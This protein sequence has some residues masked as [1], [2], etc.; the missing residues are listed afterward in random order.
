MYIG[1]NIG[2]SALHSCDQDVSVQKWILDTTQI[3]CRVSDNI[4]EMQQ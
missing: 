1:L 2:Q 4:C 3:I